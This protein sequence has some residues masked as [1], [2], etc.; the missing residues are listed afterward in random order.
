VEKGLGV[1][2]GVA[3]AGWRRGGRE[4]ELY[5][6]YDQVDYAQV[7]KSFANAVKPN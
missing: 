3:E 2:A 6:D 4:E 1:R 5:G 7:Q